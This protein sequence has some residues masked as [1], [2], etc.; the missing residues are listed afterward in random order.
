MASENSRR[1]VEPAA[2][3]ALCKTVHELSSIVSQH[4]VSAVELCKPFFGYQTKFK[5]ER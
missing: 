1:D 2:H 5:K 4:A 3:L